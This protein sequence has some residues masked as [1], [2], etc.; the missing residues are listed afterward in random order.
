[1]AAIA[2]LVAYDGETTPV[3]HTFYA[4]HVEYTGNDLIALWSEKT[5]GVPEYA[6][7]TVRLS[8]KKVAS[9]MV[10][11]GL[12]VDLPVMESV[13]GQNLSGY[14]AA[15]KVAY[16]DSSEQVQWIHSRS[17]A[18]GR[19][20]TRWILRNLTNNA[21]TSTTPVTGGF[22]YDALVRLVFPS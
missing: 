12:R 2:D 16:V 21:A 7:G 8:K 18:Q 6:Q 9:G 13:S 19:S 11:V 3:A 22:A 17:L 10:R 5:V 20:N 1:M 15:P 14:T 4:D